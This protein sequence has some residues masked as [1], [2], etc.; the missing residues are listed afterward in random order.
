[1]YILYWML[2][3]VLA[4]L[5]FVYCVNTGRVNWATLFLIIL[6]IAS[7]ISMVNG[8]MLFC[9]RSDTENKQVELEELKTQAGKNKNLK[10]MVLL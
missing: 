5:F 10:C 3:C 1:M 2:A 4:V 8:I 7:T 9:N 6:L